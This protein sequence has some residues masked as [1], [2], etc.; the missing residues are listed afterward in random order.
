MVSGIRRA[1]DTRVHW[2]NRL[3]LFREQ[4][5]F[6]GG[7]ETEVAAGAVQRRS[8]GPLATGPQDLP[9]GFLLVLITQQAGC[10]NF[11]GP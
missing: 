7:G 11:Q 3:R 9:G 1:I 4:E 2:N 6:C 10:L 8:E 5:G